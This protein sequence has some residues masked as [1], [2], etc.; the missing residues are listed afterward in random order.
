MNQPT[1]A[2]FHPQNRYHKIPINVIIRLRLEE[3]GNKCCHSSQVI[4][5]LSD[6]AVLNLF[7][8]FGDIGT[9]I[10]QL[11]IVSK[12]ASINQF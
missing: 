1:T 12:V 11:F 9:K 8:N 7:T 2:T 6:S 3:Q 5:S 4:V 10:D